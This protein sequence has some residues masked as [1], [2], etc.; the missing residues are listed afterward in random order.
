VLGDEVGEDRFRM[1]CLGNARDL[2]RL[3]RRDIGI[4]PARRRD[5]EIDQDRLGA[6]GLEVYN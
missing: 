6:R 1:L 3:R 2:E 5:D 4:E